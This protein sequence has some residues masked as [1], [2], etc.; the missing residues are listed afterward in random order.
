MMKIIHAVN[1][2]TLLSR[3][4]QTA[5]TQRLGVKPGWIYPCVKTSSN[6]HE[7]LK[8]LHHKNLIIEQRE[9][10]AIAQRNNLMTGQV[11]DNAAGET[12]RIP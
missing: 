9:N 1:T 8:M 4:V 3:Y 12:G 10:L 7:S 2:K 11:Y 6:R 5:L